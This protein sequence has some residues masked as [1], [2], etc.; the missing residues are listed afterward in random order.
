[1]AVQV[2]DMGLR[3][4]RYAVTSPT[5]RPELGVHTAPAAVRRRPGPGRG[6]PENGLQAVLS[7]G[8]VARS[9]L[10]N[11]GR[12]SHRGTGSPDQVRGRVAPFAPIRAGR[13]L[14]GAA[15][16][17]VR[18]VVQGISRRTVG[19]GRGQAAPLTADGLAAIIATA[20][21][22]R[23]RGRGWETEQVA[24]DRG[25]I[26]KAIAG[27]LFQGGLRRSE[28]AA[29]QWGDVQRAGAGV[30]VRVRR[31]KTNQTNQTGERADVRYL[32]NGAATAV[33]T[34]RGPVPA[35]F[36]PSR[37]LELDA[38]LEEVYSSTP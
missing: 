32:K 19:R 12:R 3:T 13:V 21:R 18:R 11:P 25:A 24:T 17:G 23:R 2:E 1:M 37:R 20:D 16:G 27:L 31:S 33:W 5:D 22:P 4:E 10:P 34:L 26:D 28:A 9:R 38:A 30:T 14:L 35:A 15:G 8:S 29:L 36:P 7:G 6:G